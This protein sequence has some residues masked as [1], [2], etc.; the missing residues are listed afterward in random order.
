MAVKS[1]Q[2][3]LS[4]AQYPEH[5]MY[6]QDGMK[7]NCRGWSGDAGP[8]GW[9][10]IIDNPAAPGYHLLSTKKWPECFLY[11]QSTFDGNVRGWNQADP[12]PQG[13]FK[14]VPHPEQAGF[15][16][17]TPKQW[18]DK[19]FI[20]MQGDLDGNIRGW[21]TD[22]GPKGWW[23]LLPWN[24][25][26]EQPGAQAPRGGSTRQNVPAPIVVI[27]GGGKGGGGYAGSSSGVTEVVLETVSADGVDLISVPSAQRSISFPVAQ[28]K[29]F[30]NVGRQHQPELF[31]RLVR[32]QDHL[33]CI[34]RSVFSVAMEPPATAPTLKKLSN[35][36]LV[37]SDRRVAQGE[38]VGLTDGTKIAFSG[39]D[40]SDPKFL[41]MR[42]KLVALAVPQTDLT[43]G[44]RVF[45]ATV[46]LG[47]SY[48]PNSSY[49][50]GSPMA[51][52]ASN[53]SMRSMGTVPGTLPGGLPAM[54][55]SRSSRGPGAALPPSTAAVLECTY[56][57]GCRDLASLPPDATVIPLF[58]DEPL[59]IGRQHQQNFFEQLLEGE[60]KMLTYIS[61]THLRVVLQCGR[62]S[63]LPKTCLAP[64]AMTSF[65]GLEAGPG[66]GASA[67]A[68]PSAQVLYTLRV[69][70]CSSNPILAGGREIARGTEGEIPE[71][72]HLVFQVGDAKVIE[73]RL[74]RARGQ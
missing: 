47:G 59:Q 34:S 62:S 11:V 40:A 35:S 42:V 13:W 3:R 60:P 45:P 14:F 12:G 64:G 8:Q 69:E 16:L 65:G 9:W 5:Y 53:T 44:S 23:K 32:D 51:S 52:N 61:R 29:A 15:Y 71:G 56:A 66:P 2:Y 33:M 24:L 31:E 73:F 18:E 49:G 22:P 19:C 4:T 48:A 70:N 1:G 36:G 68:P 26:I 7:G 72:G 10:R 67:G 43:C 30:G 50:G 37:V 39:T 38:L 58:Q 17:I 41:V 6:M 74:R 25:D 63:A 27:Q 55:S 21:S 57:A 28:G 20:Y 54:D 46:P